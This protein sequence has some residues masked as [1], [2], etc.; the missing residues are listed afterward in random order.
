MGDVFRTPAGE[1]VTDLVLDLFRVSSRMTAAGDR[2]VSGLRL[3]ASRW[4][5]LGSL[6]TAGRPQPV[7]WLARDMGVS[8]QNLQRIVY[9]LQKD[10]FVALKP[11]PH[12][13]RAPLVELTQQ[14]HEIYDAAMAL[15]APWANALAQGLSSDEIATARKVIAALRDRLD[16]TDGY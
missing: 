7:A 4:Q 1:A 9:E 16:S 13:R 2:L 8:R 3:T 5:I 12:H 14:G 15:Q 6:I 10:G 11:N